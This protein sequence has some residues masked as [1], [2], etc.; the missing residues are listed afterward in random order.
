M[1]TPSNNHN[2]DNDKKQSKPTVEATIEKKKKSVTV[3][4]TNH[5]LLSCY[6]DKHVLHAVKIEAAKL[7]MT[8]TDFVRYIVKEALDKDDLKPPMNKL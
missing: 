7:N 1:T 5:R 4:D 2:K 8:T 3:R 6:I